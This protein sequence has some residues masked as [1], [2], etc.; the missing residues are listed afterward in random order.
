M[1]ADEE[2]V[3]IYARNQSM[4]IVRI[5]NADIGGRR[6]KRYKPLTDNAVVGRLNAIRH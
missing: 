1:C 3:N 2:L 6:V 4:V 5:Y